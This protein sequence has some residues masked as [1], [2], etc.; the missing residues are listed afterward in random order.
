[1]TLFSS[2]AMAEAWVFPPSVSTGKLQGS[3]MHG[4]DLATAQAFWRPRRSK[5]GKAINSPHHGMGDLQ[6]ASNLP[7]YWVP[8]KIRCYSSVIHNLSRERLDELGLKPRAEDPSLPVPGPS[9]TG[10]QIKPEPVGQRLFL[11]CC[12]EKQ[13]GP[14]LSTHCFLGGEGG[15]VRH[16]G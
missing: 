8:V 16:L 1:M 14:G 4:G 15:A 7:P 10:R 3:G 13:E 11:R 9:P 12:R 2:P 6:P 5:S